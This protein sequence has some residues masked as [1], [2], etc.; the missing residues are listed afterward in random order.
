VKTLCIVD[1]STHLTGAALTRLFL[2]EGHRVVKVE[3][4][5]RPD[6]G[7]NLPEYFSALNEGK[8]H[9]LMD[10]N[11]PDD[12]QKWQA[13]LKESDGLVEAFR[14]ETK[15]NLGLTQ[16]QLHSIQPQ[17]SILSLSAYPDGDSRNSKATHDLNLQAAS[18]VL[19][20][21][22]GL[23]P[24]PLSQSY[25]SFYGAFLL[26]EMIRIS[27]ET[28]H[29]QFRRLSLLESIDQAQWMWARA[30]QKENLSPQFGQTLMSGKYPCYGIYQT[31]DRIGVS[32]AAI[33]HK[34][35]INFCN[36]LELP[37]L[38]PYGKSEG[39]EAVRVREEIQNRL[40]SKLW[41]EWAPRFEASDCCVERVIQYPER[42]SKDGIQ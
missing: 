7:R 6:P 24:I 2:L 40:G 3:N 23:S 38:I 29:G 19:D 25:G 34:F 28:G 33:E 9:F 21:F 8:E 22:S 32:V 16:K 26:S 17:L 11:N 27:K 14:P 30:F 1:A 13:L 41:S 5:L 36:A 4:S 31:L 39:P 42:W 37:L 35:W 15:S 18:G 20:L 10:W 12:L